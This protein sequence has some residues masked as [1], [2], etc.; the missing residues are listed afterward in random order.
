MNDTHQDKFHKEHQGPIRK[1]FDVEIK[2]DNS[3]ATYLS[4]FITDSN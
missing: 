4:V 2:E 3:G 1:W